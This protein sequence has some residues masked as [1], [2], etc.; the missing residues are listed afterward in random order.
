[1]CVFFFDSLNAHFCCPWK[2][3]VLSLFTFPK[4]NVFSTF[5]I[6]LDFSLNSKSNVNHIFEK[7]AKIDTQEVVLHQSFAIKS[8]SRRYIWLKTGRVTK[9][10][11]L[12]FCHKWK[13]CDAHDCYIS[14]VTEH[15]SVSL[16]ISVY[17]NFAC[18]C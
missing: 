10:S 5:E 1:M 18:K 7:Y 3:R 14:L 6:W 11:P 4:K 8:S 12:E 13:S 2:Q 17:L 9:H 16:N 15:S